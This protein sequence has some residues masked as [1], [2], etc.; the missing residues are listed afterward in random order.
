MNEVDKLI[1]EQKARE[2]KQFSNLR[3]QV[4]F[5]KEIDWSNLLMWFVVNCI[6][7]YSMLNVAGKF[8]I[9]TSIPFSLLIALGLVCATTIVKKI[10]QRTY[11]IKL[12]NLFFW[13]IV[14]FT[15][16]YLINLFVKIQNVVLGILFVGFCLTLIS[17][18]INKVRYENRKNVLFVILLIFLIIYISV[19]SEKSYVTETFNQ[20][21]AGASSLAEKSF[22]EIDNVVSVPERDYNIVEGRILELVNQERA[23]NGAPSL[24]LNSQ[25]NDWA[26]KWSE[27]MISENFF[28]HSEYNVGENIGEVPIHYN[29]EGCG[30][31][32]SNEDLAKCFVIGWIESPG[33]HANMIDRAYHITGIGVA[34]DSSKCRATQMFNW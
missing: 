16:V 29:V 14:N 21:F 19:P 3:K 4:E 15:I 9:S 20:W 10:K 18:L 13:F 5:I 2:G 31:T 22:E 1:A 26:R 32:Y 8:Q 34:C 24:K 12:W 17:Y 27:K 23:R 11:N 30:S 25:L 28:E 33:H 7:F 6:V